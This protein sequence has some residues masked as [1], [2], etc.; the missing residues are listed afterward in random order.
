MISELRNYFYLLL[1]RH[2]RDHPLLVDLNRRCFQASY[3]SLLP[4][5]SFLLEVDLHPGEDW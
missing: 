4:L 2:P 3:L 5:P 1:L